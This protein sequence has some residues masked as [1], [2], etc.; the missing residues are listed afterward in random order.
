MHVHT[1]HLRTL[2]QEEIEAWQAKQ[3]EAGDVIFPV[4]ILGQTLAKVCL[5]LQFS[6]FTRFLQV[7][8]HLSADELRKAKVCFVQELKARAECCD[9]PYEVFVGKNYPNGL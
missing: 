4:S 3:R 7:N 6:L 1:K 9:M 2:L 8:P 5:R